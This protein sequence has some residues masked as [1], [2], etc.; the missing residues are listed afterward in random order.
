M[1]KYTQEKP[2]LNATIH[3]RLVN[4]S[5]FG[6]S[7]SDSPGFLEGET[8]TD[9]REFRKA[10]IAAR[11]ASQKEKRSHAQRGDDPISDAAGASF[12]WCISLDE[13]RNIHSV[14]YQSTSIQESI[15]YES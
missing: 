14:L 13:Q 7:G 8:E 6:K 5:A 15:R 11:R 4:L 2:F 1:N 12:L 10:Y 3:G 9:R